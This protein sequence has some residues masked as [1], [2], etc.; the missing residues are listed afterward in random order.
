MGRTRRRDR[1]LKRKVARKRAR[2]KEQKAKEQQGRRDAVLPTI[3]QQASDVA[4]LLATD[5]YDEL[6]A[7]AGTTDPERLADFLTQV[8]APDTADAA[9]AGALAGLRGEP[10]PAVS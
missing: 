10:R 4:W 3:R 6:V 8:E 9:R 2:V 5:G 1:K 7:D